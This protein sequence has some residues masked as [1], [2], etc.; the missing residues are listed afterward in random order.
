MQHWRFFANHPYL[1]FDGVRPIG[2]ESSAFLER[3]RTLFCNAHLNNDHVDFISC[4]ENLKKR[5]T[6]GFD[7]VL[8]RASV[9]V[10]TRKPVI[11]QLVSNDI[12]ENK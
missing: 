5:E 11:M 6:G 4:H 10:R 1:T 2:N 7:P 12:A 3:R 8:Q 9:E